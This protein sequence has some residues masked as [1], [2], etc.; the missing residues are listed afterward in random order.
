[1]PH[2][3]EG[4]LVDLG[5]DSSKTPGGREVSFTCRIR[6]NVGGAYRRCLRPEKNMPSRREAWGLLGYLLSG[7]PMK[8]GD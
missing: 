5:W 1:M 3:A 4:S 8:Q 6:T 7:Q 2:D